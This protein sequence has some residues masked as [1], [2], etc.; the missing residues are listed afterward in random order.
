[1]K[2]K[3]KTPKLDKQRLNFQLS[4]SDHSYQKHH[5]DDIVSAQIS[6]KL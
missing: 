1:M 6:R 4:P 5:N 3:T 2:N